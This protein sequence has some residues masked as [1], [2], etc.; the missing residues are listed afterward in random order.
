MLTRI[1]AASMALFLF[2]VAPVPA[3]ESGAAN[4]EPV[5][6]MIPADWP[7]AAVIVDL[8]KLD[9]NITTV[10][11]RIAGEPPD[12]GIL[13]DIQREFGLGEAVDFTKPLALAADRLS[14]PGKPVF[15][16][17]VPSAAEKF[18]TLEGAKEE[19]G[20]WQVPG[21][22]GDSVWVKIAADYIIAAPSQD[23]LAK[24]TKPDN[25][26]LADELK[27]RMDMLAGR[28]VYAHMNI[29]PVRNSALGGLAQF[30][31]MAP[32]FAMMAGQQAGMSDA[33]MLTGVFTTLADAA[34]SLLEQIA[35]VDLALSIDEKAGRVTI[36]TGYKDGPIKSYLAKQKPAS[37]PMFSEIEE[38]AYTVAVGYHVPGTES[39]FFAYLSEQLKKALSGMPGGTPEADATRK[40][41]E[42]SLATMQ[43]LYGSIEGVN[44]VMTFSGE[45]M[46]SAGDYI[47][48]D[49]AKVIELTKK[50]LL[51]ANTLT[52]ALGGGASY[53][54]AGSAKIGDAAVEKFTMKVDPANPAA[55]MMGQ[56]LANL[57]YAI[58][59]RGG[60]VRFAMGSDKDL[61]K[62]FSGSVTKP[63]AASPQ[64]KD[65]VAQLPAK[66]N[67]VVL[68]NLAAVPA[69]IGPMLGIPPGSA[70]PS[71]DAPPVALSVS[72]SGDPA[73]VDL[74]VPMKTVEVLVKG[75][76]PPAPKA[77]APGH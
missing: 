19:G 69:M 18:K 31:Q 68:L 60:R 5:L 48:S 25:R 22:D 1:S 41:I 73:R 14:G 74:Y 63:L 76:N 27:G 55:A 32:M 46:K 70:P 15:W 34:K 8:K 57:Q 28:D 67:A 26:S 11:T 30:G 4:F 62:T 10:A 50:S 61:E 75:L 44:Q 47:T 49:P 23:L 12:G 43:Q 58:G 54:S 71:G 52:K 2:L 24:A 21:S 16:A 7:V 20:V 72:L 35:Y 66:H 39:P 36:A 77:P 33:T 59:V 9:A 45:G 38:Q 17:R 40:G 51:A 29:E 37:G 6:K 64:V 3:A 42:E 53:E 13:E 56:M 65:A